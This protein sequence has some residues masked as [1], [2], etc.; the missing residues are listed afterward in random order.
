LCIRENDENFIFINGFLRNKSEYLEQLEQESD[1]D[2]DMEDSPQ[3]RQIRGA[4]RARVL[5]E[6]KN[7]IAS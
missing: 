5:S 6:H 7:Q 4:S 1:E 2:T 3:R